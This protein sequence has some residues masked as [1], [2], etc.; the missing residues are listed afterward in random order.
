MTIT[1]HF[2]FHWDKPTYD[3]NINT[4]TGVQSE[5]LFCCTRIFI[6]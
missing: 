5:D 1:S 4:I 6:L 3:D 2:P